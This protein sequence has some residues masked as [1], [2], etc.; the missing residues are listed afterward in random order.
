MC[1]LH[2]RAM[3]KEGAGSPPT[4]GNQEPFIEGGESGK[5]PEEKL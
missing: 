5:G 4:K 1:P 3:V 2:A